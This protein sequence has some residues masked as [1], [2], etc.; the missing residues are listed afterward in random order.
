MCTRRSSVDKSR[1]DTTPRSVSAHTHRR[2][3]PCI[4]LEFNLLQFSRLNRPILRVPK[5]RPIHKSSSVTK[6]Y[7]WLFW[8]VCS[9]EIK[10]NL[11]GKRNGAEMTAVL[12]II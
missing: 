6:Q 12:S 7:C 10:I 1:V 8:I 3:S 11:K 9:Q 2:S 5:F 4:D